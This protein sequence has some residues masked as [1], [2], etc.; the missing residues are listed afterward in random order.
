MYKAK[1][2]IR[3]LYKKQTSIALS[4]VLICMTLILLW[5]T[6][7]SVES[8]YH[9]R[10]NIYHMAVDQVFNSYLQQA[11]YELNSA[12][13][14]LLFNQNKPQPE[15]VLDIILHQHTK[16][17]LGGLDFFYLKWAD[18]THVIDPKS[19]LFTNDSYLN[20]TEVSTIGGWSLKKTTDD[21]N[22]LVF[23]KSLSMTSGEWRGYLYGYIVLEENLSLLNALLNK[24]ELDAVKLFSSDQE[25]LLSGVRDGVSESSLYFY[26]GD[27]QLSKSESI[28]SLHIAKKALE[29][30]SIWTDYFF[31]IAALVAM[32]LLIYFVFLNAFQ[33][34]ISS[35]LTT[36][37]KELHLAKDSSFYEIQPLQKRL[38]QKFHSL[39]SQLRSFDL[40]MSATDSIIIFCD[41]VACVQK[42]NPQAIDIFPEC[43]QS[44]TVFDFMPVECHLSI[45]QALKGEVGIHFSTTLANTKKIYYWRL[46]PYAMDSNY[47]G[48]A[49]IGRDVTD[50]QQLEWQLTEL[51]EYVPENSIE[52]SLILDELDYVLADTDNSFS[53]EK[54][55]W[56]KSL[57]H[58]LNKL[59]A[60][61]TQLE[62]AM[63]LG[64]FLNQCLTITPCHFQNM[65]YVQI[66]CPIN[67]ANIQNAWLSDTGLLINALLMMAHS[68]NAV[69]KKFLSINILD[70]Q[71]KVE[72]IGVNAPRPIFNALVYA[73][74]ARLGVDCKLV[75]SNH[76]VATYPLLL[77]S[78]SMPMHPK[79]LKVAWIKN[80]Y[81][82]PALIVEML[83]NLGHEVHTF[84]SSESFFSE[85]SQLTVIDALLI[86]YCEQQP[87][88]HQLPTILK[89]RLQR[90]SLPV[91]WIGPDKKPPV[92][93]LLNYFGCVHEYGLSKF[94][95]TLTK[96]ESIDLQASLL[97]EDSWLISGG[98]SVSR[99]I[100]Y[101]ELLHFS[102]KSHL[103]DTPSEHH[104]LF[105]NNTIK[106]LLLLDESGE[107]EAK[108]LQ[109]QFPNLIVISV[110]QG[111]TK[112][113]G[114]EAY[115][116]DKPYRQ[117]QIQSLIEFVAQKLT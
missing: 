14:L 61:S 87:I 73:V 92:D 60:P 89:S 10:L 11:E 25:L 22:L 41:E 51:Q 40:L 91:G 42:V 21:K 94:L 9:S 33:R 17:L 15:P 19:H 105:A 82:L 37:E 48:L 53:T 74:A 111:T 67:S 58:C 75:S 7:R 23:K 50:I 64:E 83:E 2:S 99:T 79:K 26:S 46:F 39:Q 71:L 69:G 97:D 54:D 12:A 5:H 13:Q 62:H 28:Y 18:G 101:E 104:H 88:W 114:I 103:I 52:T 55:N 66:D 95:A 57:S 29:N 56:L 3:T 16:F 68:S 80:D 116:L 43:S 65:S 27:I 107:T 20:I 36:V 90:T 6:K 38:N 102:V 59:M 86:G 32:L 110:S 45:Q 109:A 49:L 44:R 76:L 35:I 100:L 84:S 115:P 72:A 63:P 98:S 93:E 85:V 108:A 112:H 47:Q 117:T 30:T 77:N 96:Y 78:P 106:V 34:T 4:C 31:W 81:M 70:N 8:Y 1:V 113:G 24:T